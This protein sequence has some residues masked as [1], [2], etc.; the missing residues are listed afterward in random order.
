V[1]R[2]TLWFVS[3]V[4]ALVVLFSYHTSTNSGGASAS[5]IAPAT[6]GSSATSTATATPSASATAIPT[7]TATASTGSTSSSTKSSSSSS[8]TASASS[9]SGTYTGTSVDTRWGPVQVKVTVK[10]GKVTDVQAVV[11]PSGNGR[12]QEINAY[13]LPLLHDEVLQAQSA[14]IDAV[15]GATVTS[16]GYISSLQSALDQ[17]GVTG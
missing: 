13:A 16:D 3:T 15:S 17:A 6:P 9:T 4:S 1:R 2:V 11:Y 8:S 14:Q 12:D 5:A 7:P 10:A